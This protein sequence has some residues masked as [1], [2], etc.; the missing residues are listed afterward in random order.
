MAFGL[1]TAGSIKEAYGKLQ[2]K[3]SRYRDQAEKATGVAVNTVETVGTAALLAY[4]RGRYPSTKTDEK[5]K[6]VAYTTDLLVAGIPVS[7]IVGLGGH[8]AGFAGLLGKYS[9]HGHAVGSGALAEYATSMMFAVG[10][11][12][13]AE[14]DKENKKAIGTADHPSPP[15]ISGGYFATQNRGQGM[16]GAAYPTPYAATYAG[17]IGAMF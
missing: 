3:W 16:V 6:K 15:Q 7:L 2:A 12:A 5:T 17:P 14:A 8:V 10:N 13:R 1:T 4:L 11:K 9:E